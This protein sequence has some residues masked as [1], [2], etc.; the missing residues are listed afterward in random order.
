VEIASAE[1]AQRCVR[2]WLEFELSDGDSNA[3][4]ALENHV[5]AQAVFERARIPKPLVV[6]LNLAGGDF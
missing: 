1:Q 6:S 5:Q 4:D 2:R 3:S